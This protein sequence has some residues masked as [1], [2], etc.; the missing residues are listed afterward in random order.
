MSRG[1]PGWIQAFVMSYLEA[2]DIMVDY[3]SFDDVISYRTYYMMTEAA[4]HLKSVIY[5][6]FL[7]LRPTTPNK[8]LSGILQLS[9]LLQCMY[10]TVEANEW[11]DTRVNITV[12]C[13]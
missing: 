12:L 1:I 11:A 5:F 9:Q 6:V 8:H 13:M 7:L 2:G 4:S 10:N 3:M